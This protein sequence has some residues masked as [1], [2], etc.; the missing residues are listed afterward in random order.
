MTIRELFIGMG[1]KVDDKNAK[2]SLE[3]MQ[4]MAGTL[5]KVLG[6]L[7]VG[8]VVKDMLDAGGKLQQSIGGIE[9]LYGDSAEAVKM[10]KDNANNA[11]KTAGMSANKYMENAISFAGTLRQTTDSAE[12]AAKITDMIMTNMSDNVNKM[13]TDAGM[14]ENTYRGL[15]RNNYMINLMSAA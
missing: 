4:K 13:G 7:A 6:A 15:A 9:T 10:L 12:E 5:K 1:Y 2:K 11:Y 14:V 8:A 3:G